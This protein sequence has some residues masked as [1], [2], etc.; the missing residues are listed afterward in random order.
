MN[1][2]H[3]RKKLH[4]LGLKAEGYKP[5]CGNNELKD[6]ITDLLRV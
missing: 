1:L 2:I 6:S 4:K 5:Q 3:P